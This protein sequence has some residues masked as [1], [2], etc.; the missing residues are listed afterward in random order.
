MAANVGRNVTFTPT[1]GGAAIIGART[2]SISLN[3]E[4]VDI[5]SDD[6]VGWQT[7]LGTDPAQRG[8]SMSIAG[9][10][11]D[12]TL[13]DLAATDGAALISEYTLVIEAI[14]TFT[15]DFHI[16][17]ISLEAPYNDAVT[18]TAEVNSSGPLVWEASTT[19]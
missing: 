1:V 8:V 15:G 14:G 3:N 9:V 6:D 11:K 5:T 19:A 7:F 12:S 4:A 17:N 2:K 16:G 10:L 13:I 18:F